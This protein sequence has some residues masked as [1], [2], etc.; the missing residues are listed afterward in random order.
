MKLKGD[1]QEIW[2]TLFYCF[3]ENDLELNAKLS[4]HGI[5]EKSILTCKTLGVKSNGTLFV[6]FELEKSEKP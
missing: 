4:C 1:T 5:I 2:K 6:L 3:Y